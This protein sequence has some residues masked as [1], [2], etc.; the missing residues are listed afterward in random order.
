MHC[1]FNK[2]KK[3]L[4]K[5]TKWLSIVRL[6]PLTKTKEATLSER[7]FRCISLQCTECH[8]SVTTFIP[9]PKKKAPVSQKPDKPDSTRWPYYHWKIA[10]NAGK[11]LNVVYS[12]LV[13]NSFKAIFDNTYLV[14]HYNQRNICLY[15]YVCVFSIEKIVYLIFVY[16]VLL[17]QKSL[18]LGLFELWQQ[19][20]KQIEVREIR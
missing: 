16:F 4:L 17:L 1:C 20:L 19:I 7:Y 8:Q 18:A 15:V 9:N 12:N 5:I 3:T 6:I 10:Y 13:L 11:H 2:K 14:Q